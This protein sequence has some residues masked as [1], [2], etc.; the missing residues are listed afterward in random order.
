MTPIAETPA[1]T[2]LLAQLVNPAARSLALSV[3]VGLGLGAFRVK[4]TSLR[5]FTWTAVL[6]AAL[7]MPFLGL[8]LP[9]LLIHAPPALQKA[10]LHSESG[11]S[12]LRS[13]GDLVR[14]QNR[15]TPA[16]KE[17]NN[18]KTSEPSIAH[19]NA[20]W[21]VRNQHVQPTGPKEILPAHVASDRYLS[22]IQWTEVATDV[23]LA[24]ALILLGR[25]LVGLVFGHRL[26]QK[27][28][29]IDEPRLTISLAA[30]AN[31]VGLPSLPRVAE[32]KLIS[33]P[34]TT[35]AVRPTIL[36]PFNW[37]T[38]DVAKLD[39][40]LAH[41]VSHVARRD[42]LTQD[43]AILHRAIFWF[44]PL[45]WWLDR[46][47]ADLAEQASD[48]AALACGAD[49]KDYA[50]TL[51]RF[52]EALQTAPG[53]VW[54]QGVSMA[55]AGQAEQRIERILSWKG[56]VAMHVKKSIT[57][58]V[59]AFAIPVVYVAASV[60]PASAHPQSPQP[61][62]TTQAPAPAATAEPAP[63]PAP[64]AEPTSAPAGG[65]AGHISGGPPAPDMPPA[66]EDGVAG[67]VAGPAPVPPAAPTA[68]IDP[69]GEAEPAAPEQSSHHGFSYHYG[70]DD[71]DRFVIVSGK[72][73][74]FTMSGTGQDARHVEKLRKNI[75][76]DF[77]WFQRDEK[78]YVIRDQATIDRAKKVWAPQE[79]LGKK[80]EA[81]GKQ[82]E[83][84]GKQ[85]EEL[86]TRMREIR[87]NIPDMT[88]E[89][90]KLKAELQQL[91]SGATVEQVGHLQSEIGE[92]QSKIGNIQSHAG[93]QQGKIGEEMGALGAKQSKLGELQGELGRQQGELWREASRQ[94]KQLLDEAI[95]K[96]LAQP[97]L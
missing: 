74:S 71:E 21:P 97:E 29:R 16:L 81:L 78:S 28:K 64:E 83:A 57:V 22:S 62:A 5:L 60:H 38:W 61:A 50:R 72:T 73:D 43:L 13:G 46:H 69:I 19:R 25:F 32:S 95:A 63:A 24:V 37:R 2:T 44:S 96:G 93:D 33:V 30:R 9:P 15:T 92:L 80:Q 55:K 88:A 82:Q 86:G 91:S 26:L 31:A 17:V 58:A 68:P 49:R 11:P 40:V 41:E 6:Y 59:V 36:L 51:L 35:G 3:M 27:S 53:R 54:W 39:A 84:L 10:F 14:N 47:L 85:Q 94:M 90:D 7:A 66:P 79:E 77:I 67:G 45:S 89:L 8:T 18:T 4:T 65:V 34:L 52:F 42:A 56:T 76:G 48:E 87:V 12:K 70:F 1:S 23:Y 75:Q 20:E